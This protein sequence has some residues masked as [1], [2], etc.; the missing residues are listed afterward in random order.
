MVQPKSGA[1]HTTGARLTVYPTTIERCRWRV[2]CIVSA[3]NDWG[4]CLIRRGS[5]YVSR[6]QRTTTLTI[7]DNSTVMHST[8]THVLLWQLTYTY[9]HVY[10]SNDL[11]NAA[12]PRTGGDHAVGGGLNL[13]E[14]LC[15]GL[16][17]SGFPRTPIRHCPPR[18]SRTAANTLPIGVGVKPQELNI[19]T[20]Q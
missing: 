6:G 15:L 20:L 12:P 11:Y 10:V 19:G 1:V 2:G 9:D 17:S 5:W 13:K 3:V 7:P 8:L 18:T 16:R 4:G 14:Q